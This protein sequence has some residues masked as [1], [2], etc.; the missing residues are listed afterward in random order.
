[1]KSLF[2]HSAADA[3]LVMLA[4]VY[5]A[6]LCAGAI[7]FS[8]IPWY[9]LVAIGLILPVLD[10][11]AQNGQHYHSH[12][13]FFVYPRIN[14]CYSLILSALYGSPQKLYAFR[15]AWHHGH[16]Y[17][18]GSLMHVIN[19]KPVWWVEPLRLA[20]D[21]FGLWW[22]YKMWEQRSS[23][24]SATRKRRL[25]SCA[26]AIIKAWGRMLERDE[27][28]QLFYEKLGS[29]N[30]GSRRAFL[31]E[32][33]ALVVFRVA[34]LVISPS[35][36]CWYLLFFFW[37]QIV[38]GYQ[39]FCEHYGTADGDRFRD[40]VSCYNYWY[41]R[42]YFNNGYHQEHHINPRCHWT[43]VPEMRTQMALEE[44]RRVVP[45][46]HWTNPLVA[47]RTVRSDKS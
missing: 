47:L 27:R 3:A 4:L 1:M 15:H 35:F 31:R 43:R 8:Q 11:T 41:N 20:L 19:L 37:A 39:E 44:S 5:L 22:I 36:F 38:H 10:L 29:Q 40:S 17:S 18:Y 25:L 26:S 30:L 21:P 16:T 24:V 45:A 14:H 46:L 28:T 34:L 23:A 2:K 32:A 33:I 6:I 12:T 13:A 7:F 42:L 9:F